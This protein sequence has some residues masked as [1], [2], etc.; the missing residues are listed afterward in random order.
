MDIQDQEMFV[1]SADIIGL[2]IFPSQSSSFKVKF[3]HEEKNSSLNPN[4][5]G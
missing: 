3:W 1:D 2:V 5:F 4:K